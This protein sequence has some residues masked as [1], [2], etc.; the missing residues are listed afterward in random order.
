MFHND[1]L[2]WDCLRK[3]ISELSTPTSVI[4][5]Y[6]LFALHRKRVLFW[7]KPAEK[8]PLVMNRGQVQR[9][10]RS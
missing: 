1:F 4:M 9:K 2:F 10:F 6:M 8:K 7:A 3:F 5:Q